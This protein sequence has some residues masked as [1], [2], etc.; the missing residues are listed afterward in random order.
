MPCG[1]VFATPGFGT[2]GKTTDSAGKNGDFDESDLSRRETS[3]GD[4]SQEWDGPKTDVSRIVSG[5][6]QTLDQVPGIEVAI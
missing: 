5:S 4:R 3:R 2:G 6:E 1:C